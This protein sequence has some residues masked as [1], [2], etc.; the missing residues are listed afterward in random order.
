MSWKKR[1]SLLGLLYVIAFTTFLAT[2][3]IQ[4]IVFPIIGIIVYFVLFFI[5]LY[6]ANH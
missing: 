1:L 4:I 5:D 6:K 2:I 3:H